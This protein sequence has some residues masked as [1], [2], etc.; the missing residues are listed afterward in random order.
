MARP[1]D[2]IL[3]ATINIFDSKARMLQSQLYNNLGKMN[4]S[5]PFHRQG[6]TRIQTS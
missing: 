3:E 4:L 6:L 2:R 1:N 5:F